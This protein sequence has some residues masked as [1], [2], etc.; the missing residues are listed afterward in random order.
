MLFLMCGFFLVVIGVNVAMA[1]SASRTWTGLVVDNSYVES[2]RFQ[3][4]RDRTKAQADRGWRFSVD[5]RAGSIFFQA[6]DESGSPLPLEG[7]AA[8]LRRPVGGHD[9]RS[10]AL[11][12]DNA[13]YSVPLQLA[14]GVWDVT[15]TTGQ[16]SL[17]PIEVER[18]ITVP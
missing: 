11:R 8:F 1:V 15:V 10:V 13:G 18:R 17:G 4:K 5:Y 2:Q 7:V 12:W 3:A 14:A 6:E 16:T 9:D